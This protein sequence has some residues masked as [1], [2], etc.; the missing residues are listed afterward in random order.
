[1]GVR[2]AE[3]L[4]ALSLATDLSQGQTLEWELRA[5]RLAL[6]L[7]AEVGADLREVYDLALLRYIGCTGHAH[8]VAALLGDDVAVRGRAPLV[9]L[10]RLSAVLADTWRNAGPGVA[11]GLVARGPGPVKESF[12][13]GCEV[14][15]LLAD[16]L[17]FAGAAVE[18]LAFAFERWDGRGYPNRVK[19]EAVPLPMRIVQLA[20][21]ADAWYRTGGVEP[22]IDLARSRAGGAHD[23]ALVEVF[24][25]VGPGVLAEIHAESAW[26]AV[27]DAE[28]PPAVMIDSAGLA[29]ACAVVADYADLKSAYTAGHSR[30]VAE[31]VA[32]AARACHLPAP[33]VEEAE[34]AALLHDLG[35]T[36][37]SN[38]VWD[39]PGPLT[40]SEWERVRL[41]PYYTERM[42]SR[43]PGLAEAASLGS[44]HHER[45]DGKG[46]HRG[47]PGS[48]L[49][50]P[51][52]LLAAADAYQAMTQ[53][54]AHR[55][56][57]APAEAAAA[58]R[59]DPL[60][61][62][63][64]VEAV[65]GAAGHR[66]RRTATGDLTEREIEVLRLVARGQTSKQVATSL[67]VSRRTVDH[68]IAHIYDK[69]GVS[70]RGAVVLWALQN[71][72]TQL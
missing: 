13:A 61:D 58:L 25:R 9:D 62:P 53:A 45:Q 29:D 44:Y 65:L 20:Q 35:R 38:A 63:D 27:L 11:L 49:P 60:L 56:A 70:T 5:C 41:H 22:A 30:G 28:P 7:A 24:C 66:W 68:H 55:A 59:A 18:S 46:Y 40:E 2:R 67:G 69:T 36:A 64:A 19:A 48:V 4:C 57:R 23:P 34:R 37:I 14:A 71:G 17:G 39:K 10:G 8:E 1:M 32:G 6:V 42:L 54:R 3:L 15:R 47:V 31:L 52:R 16:R 12:R 43:C 21:D 51:A 72:I 26:G 50:L 33:E